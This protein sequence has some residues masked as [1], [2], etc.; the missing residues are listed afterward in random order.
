M[1][2]KK[3]VLWKRLLFIF[4]ALL[5][6][7]FLVLIGLNL[8]IRGQTQGYIVSV[9]EAKSLSDV[10]C[11]LVLGCAV[12]G[13]TPSLMLKDRLDRSVELFHEGVSSKLL[14]SG[15]HRGPDYDEVNVMKAYAVNQGV[16][17]ELVFMDHAGF[18]TYDS[19]YR[20]LHVFGV[21][22]MVIVSQEYHLYRALYIAHSLGID[23]Y[24]VCAADISYRGDFY[25]E[26]R[27][28]VAR[29]KDCVLCLFKPT[30][31]YL[32]DFTPISGNGHITDDGTN[33]KSMR[34]IS[35]RMLILS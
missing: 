13:E 15:D 21:K 29:V 30:S 32:D 2:S 22:R 12:R 17:P 16:P 23:A 20:A 26:A 10:D 35:E 34:P 5:L 9:D 8:Y 4:F 28:M 3:R 18:S 1:A 33:Y 7:G 24:G 19:V 25:R 27:E 11:I 6:F 14:M 31:E